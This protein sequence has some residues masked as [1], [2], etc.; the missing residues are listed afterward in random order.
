VRAAMRTQ[1][2][3][4]G[5]PRPPMPVSSSAQEAKIGLAMAELV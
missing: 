2:R 3:E 1:G 4:G 5:V